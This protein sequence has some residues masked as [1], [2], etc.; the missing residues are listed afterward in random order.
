MKNTH[1][2]KLVFLSFSLAFFSFKA[3]SPVPCSCPAVPFDSLAPSEYEIIFCGKVKEVKVLSNDLHTV[4]FE[5]SELYKGHV[6][7]NWDVHFKKD[8][9][10]A[11]EFKPGDEWLMFLN[12]YQNNNSKLNWCSHSRKYFRTK[13][14]DPFWIS[15]GW[16]YE[17][18]KSFLK[19]KLGTY[20]ILENVGTDAKARNVL[21][22]RW[23]FFIYL[24]A[25]AC[26]MFLIYYIVKK[27]L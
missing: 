23:E 24:F 3:Q 25:S 4:V 20:K 26:G 9:P 17:D 6:T 2:K 16:E 11:M 7:R 12:Y 10:C 22:N 18:V 19:K 21:P 14:D 8:D 15:S 27:Y 1:F 5:V 13:T